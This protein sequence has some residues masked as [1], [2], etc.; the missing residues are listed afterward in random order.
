MA[1]NPLVLIGILTVFYWVLI[2]I[3]TLF[4]IDGVAVAEWN[5]WGLTM[6]G[7]LPM[8]I[9]SI[10]VVVSFFLGFSLYRLFVRKA[11][12]M[13]DYHSQKAV[14]LAGRTLTPWVLQLALCFVVCCVWSWVLA[15][16]LGS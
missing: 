16:S 1:H 2:A 5:V 3:V 12:R 13:E 10:L 6:I 11:K 7:V 14:S 9:L 4:E 8:T 15:W